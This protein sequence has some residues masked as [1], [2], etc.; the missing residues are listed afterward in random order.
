M[1]KEEA[2]ARLRDYAHGFYKGSKNRIPPH[3]FDLNRET[4]DILEDAL[5]KQIPKAYVMDVDTARC[6]ECNAVLEKQSMVGDN[7]LFHE[8]FEYCPNCGQSIDWKG[9]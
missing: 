9:L 7:V 1:T 8:F 5:L 2:L 4:T 6:P 3:S